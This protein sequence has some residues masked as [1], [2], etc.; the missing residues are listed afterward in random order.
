M[1]NEFLSHEDYNKQESN[2]KEENEGNIFKLDSIELNLNKI[3]NQ[4][5]A[6]MPFLGYRIQINN[7]G[8]IE[9]VLKSLNVIE[10][11][12]TKTLY[13]IFFI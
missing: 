3:C 8:K 5:D 7:I 6:L 10:I 13:F 1:N 4:Y 9:N 12:T 11:I 2:I